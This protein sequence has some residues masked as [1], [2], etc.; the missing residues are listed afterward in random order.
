MSHLQQVIEEAWDTRD[1][2]NTENGAD[3]F[4]SSIEKTITL[5]DEGG[6]R[7][8]EKN[9]DGTWVTNEWLKKAV[10][11]YFK[12]NDNQVINGGVQNYYD[13]VPLKFAN[14]GEDT[15]RKGGMRVVP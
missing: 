12:L 15:F 8:A 13:K 1:A 4:R 5:L 9:A 7:V 3:P 2:W 10:L 6:V 11:L 14:W